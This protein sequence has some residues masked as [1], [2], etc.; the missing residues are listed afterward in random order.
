MCLLNSFQNKL[1]WSHY[2]EAHKSVC[3]TVQVPNQLVYP[4]CYSKK[5]VFDDSDIDQLITESKKAVKKSVDKS[6]DNLSYFKKVAYIKDR[7]W[8]YE[9]EYRI[10]FDEKDNNGL[11]YDD[12]KWYMSVKIKNIYLGVNFEKND[13]KTKQAI[14]SACKKHKIKITQMILDE[15]TYSIR[16]DSQ[17]R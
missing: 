17:R 14:L 7:K 13:S 4:V 11:I 5:K 9:K 8:E 12:G 2:S 10:V 3:V 1:V 16:V 6:F 15:N